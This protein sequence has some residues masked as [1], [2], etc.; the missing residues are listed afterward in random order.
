MVGV[1]GKQAFII[2]L[3]AS[4]SEVLQ[5]PRVGILDAGCLLQV[6][7]GK[8]KKTIRQH[9]AAAGRRLL[10]QQQHTR[11]GLRRLERRTMTG[12]PAADHHYVRFARP[13]CVC[14][15]V[16]S[17]FQPRAGRGTLRA[18]RPASSALRG[19]VDPRARLAAQRQH[20]R[21]SAGN[22]QQA[23]SHLRF[24]LTVG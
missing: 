9:R 6:G 3:A 1:N 18:P 21:S 2:L 13:L 10:F 24:P 14:H 5:Q 4:P 12:K 19:L 11:A 7:S 17:R 23:E 22:P 8:S 16:L 15:F 20:I